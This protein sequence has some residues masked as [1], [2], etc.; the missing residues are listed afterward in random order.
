[1]TDNSAANNSTR[2]NPIVVIQAPIGAELV[3]DN[4]DPCVPSRK[5]GFTFESVVRSL[6]FDTV[7]VFTVL[8]TQSQFPKPQTLGRFHRVSRIIWETWFHPSASRHIL[9]QNEH[10]LVLVYRFELF[11][12]ARAMWVISLVISARVLVESAGVQRKHLHQ[13][14]CISK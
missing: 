1:M 13:M 7:L 10:I 2:D 9:L 6:S 11:S 12:H 4:S 14:R 3:R 5:L 8:G